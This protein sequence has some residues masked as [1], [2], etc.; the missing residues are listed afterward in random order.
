[1]GNPRWAAAVKILKRLLTRRHISKTANPDEAVRIV[2][3][4]E[5]TNNMG[6][7]SFLWFDEVLLKERNQRVAVSSIKCLLA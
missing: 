7:D 5:S 2:D 6:T 1:M 4:A 3:I